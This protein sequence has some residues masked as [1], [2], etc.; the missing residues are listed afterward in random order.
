[1]KIKLANEG[2][3]RGNTITLEQIN[4]HA[5]SSLRNTEEGTKF[6]RDFVH[7]KSWSINTQ[8]VAF[9]LKQFIIAYNSN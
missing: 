5:M 3:K 6:W 4:K 2:A 7:A 8:K 9:Y 1:M